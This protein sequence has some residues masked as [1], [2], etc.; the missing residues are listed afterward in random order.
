MRHERSSA[1]SPEGGMAQEATRYSVGVDWGSARHQV[2]VLDATGAVVQE[3][4]IEH[5]GAALGTWV[6]RLLRRVEDDASRLAVAIEVP[7][8]PVVE[9]LLERGIPTFSVNPKQLAA[10]RDRAGAA[11]AKDDRRDARL[12]AR[13]LQTDPH[14]FRALGTDDPLVIQLREWSRMDAELV[15]ELGRLTNRLREQWQRYYVQLLELSPAAT[16]A[17][18]WRL[19]ER[20][21]TP[22]AGA[23]LR[24]DTISGIVHAYHLRRWTPVQ[25]KTVLRTPALVVAPGTVE[26]ATAHARYLI[27]RLW[28][29]QQ[30]R[31]SCTKQLEALLA[32]L[33]DPAE[34]PGSGPSDVTILRSM[35][36]VG[37]VVAAR[38]L[39]EAAH[40]IAAR[41]LAML[42]AWAGLAPVTR[43]SGKT[44]LVV[45]RTACNHAL[46]NA[47]YFWA[48]GSLKCDAGSRHYYRQLRARGHTHGRAL[49]DVADRLLRILVAMLKTRTLYD[50]TCC[51]PVLSM[52]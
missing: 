11:G 17:W 24:L 49:R 23:R 52:P 15:A 29:V 4:A 46:R 35:P 26:A 36:G 43:Q 38:F 28:L 31:E 7:R 48:L 22:A 3:E 9:V 6:A 51:A 8:G 21:P 40:P 16:D 25:V 39:A 32:Q 2:C 18:V 37:P 27:E 41:A 10:F 5:T 14:C 50:A 33:E 1:L 47:C 44:R 34:P 30:Q 12:L 42:R 19:W 13:A 20:A 45:M